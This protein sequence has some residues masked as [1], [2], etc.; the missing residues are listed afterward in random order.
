MNSDSSEVDTGKIFDRIIQAKFELLDLERRRIW[1]NH[2]WIDEMIDRTRDRL[3]Q[4]E[5][6][7]EDNS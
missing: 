6:M 4:L 7:Q 3:A 2:P 5:R 1:T